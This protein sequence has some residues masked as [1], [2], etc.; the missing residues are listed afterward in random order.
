MHGLV[1]LAVFGAGSGEGA[2]E[3]SWMHNPCTLLPGA[4]QELFTVIGAEWPETV[5][6]ARAGTTVFLGIRM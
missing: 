6:P 3:E 1:R 2:L 5:V 4:I